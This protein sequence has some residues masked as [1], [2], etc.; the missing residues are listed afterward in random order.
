MTLIPPGAVKICGLREPIHAEAAARSGADLLGFIFA[1]SRRQITPDQAAECIAAARQA[2]GRPILTVGVFVDAP[3][4]TMNQAAEVA[5]LDLLQLHGDEP[6]DILPDLS[7]LVIK[8]FRPAPGTSIDDLRSTLDRYLQSD[9]SPVAF[10][11][12][13]YHPTLHGGGGV[14]A[15]WTLASEIASRYDVIL[16]GGL[17]PDNVAEA[18]QTVAP[19]GVDVSSGVEREGRK[20]PGLIAR[21]ITAAKAAFAERDALTA[22]R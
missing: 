16:A 5:G 15:D 3:V 4:E 13:G 21:F 9:R 8:A 18:I 1:P 11:I 12:D 7:R 10:L 2:A 22:D 6:P 19:R 14:R 20:E 17:D